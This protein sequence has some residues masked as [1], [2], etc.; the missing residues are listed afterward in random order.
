MPRL[1]FEIDI[2]CD[3]G[4][5]LFV[6]REDTPDDPMEALMLAGSFGADLIVKIRCS[7][8]VDKDVVFDAAASMEGRVALSDLDVMSI[9]TDKNKNVL[10]LFR[11]N[12]KLLVP[13]DDDEEEEEEEEEDDLFDIILAGHG[14]SDPFANKDPYAHGEE[15]VE[16]LDVTDWGFSQLF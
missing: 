11:E 8:E 13:P 12:V 7:G 9:I 10:V 16:D 14:K 5:E 3:G 6:A 1:V 2:C 4:R 15:D